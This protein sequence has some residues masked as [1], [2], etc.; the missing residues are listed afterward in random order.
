MVNPSRCLFTFPEPVNLR[1]IAIPEICQNAH[2]ALD[3][4]IRVN[5]TDRLE[6]CDGQ[7]FLHAMESG[8][9]LRITLPGRWDR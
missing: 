8:V 5:P 7:W 2:F 1:E 4:A 9:W 6:L 3:H